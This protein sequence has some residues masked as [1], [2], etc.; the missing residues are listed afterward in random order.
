MSRKSLIFCL[1]VL[2]VMI[3]GT[4]VA[5]AVLYSGTGDGA[6]RKTQT[7][8]DQER[9][10]LL[11]A[12]PADAAL[13]AC[14]SDV[15]EAMGGLLSGFD[16][17]AVLADSIAAGHFRS[18]ASSRLAVSMHYSGELQTLYV[19]DAGK[20][21][22]EPSADASA[23]ISFARSRNMSAEYMDCSSLQDE[24]RSIS[25]RSVVIISDSDPLVKSSI[26]HLRNGVS[27]MD[28]TGFATVSSEVAGKNVVFFSNAHARML[29]SGILTKNML[30]VTDLWL[31]WR[32]GLLP[33]FPRLMP[34]EYL[35]PFP[36]CLRM[37]LLT[38]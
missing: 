11:P 26:R 23:L 21:S 35:R 15:E 20:A 10:M 19:F 17:P 1:A 6:S 22:K 24:D 4:G 25:K 33:A 5:V 29:M 16:F 28:A 7:V 3:L 38:L 13:A 36:L 9:Y 2:A 8:P 14:F 32:N 37:I 34:R 27:I 12:V 30:H 31:I 18:I